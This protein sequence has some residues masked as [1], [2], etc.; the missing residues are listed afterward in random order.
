M[1]YVME[2]EEEQRGEEGGLD[3]VEDAGNPLS[4]IPTT[5][6][7]SKA[8]VSGNLAHQQAV[9]MSANDIVINKLTQILSYLRAAGTRGKKRKKDKLVPQLPNPKSD[10]VAAA[11]IAKGHGAELPIFD[12]TG[13][14]V[15]DY[16]KR[17][18]KS[19]NNV[20]SRDRDRD[21]RDRDK[22]YS[23]SGHRDR[24]RGYSRS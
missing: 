19:S 22:G 6:I 7:R 21:R 12:D 3:A 10:P 9:S 13:D 23:R 5:T 4:D 17:S 20:S 15:P 18:D 1:A 11:A 2:L 8:D 14:Y 24:E 16:T